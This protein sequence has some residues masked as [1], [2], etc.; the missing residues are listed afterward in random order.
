MPA[1]FYSVVLIGLVALSASARADQRRDY[2]LQG[3]P[4][5]D[6]LVLDYFGTGGQLTLDHRR[7]IYGETNSYAL[8]AS[9]LV[10]YPL[11]QVSATAS[12]R[13]VF[14]ELSV[15]GGYRS[16]WRN[17]SFQ[18]GDHS[19]CADCDRSSRRRQDPLFGSGPDTD[20]YGFAEATAQIYAPFNE[21]FVFTSLLSARYE[22]L[23]PRSYDYFYTDIHDPGVMV[24]WEALAFFKHRDWGAIGPYLQLLSLPRDGH[25]ESE[26]A[27]GF[28][29]LTRLGLIARDDLV[30]VTFL[31]RPGDRYYGQHS[32]YAPVRALINYRIN[33]AL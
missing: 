26:F 11:G 27:V 4:V 9:A 12:L 13:I 5:G 33:F 32:Y 6:R 3:D 21:Y 8:N 23:R 25:H 30:F 1:R 28:N 7:P 20:S 14:L 29:A 19:Y 2:P 18:P 17:L 24:R 31:I 10:G 16:V 15:T 22:G